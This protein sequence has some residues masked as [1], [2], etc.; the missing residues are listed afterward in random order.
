MN[1]T[2]VMLDQSDKTLHRPGNMYLKTA[3]GVHLDTVTIGPQALIA[4][5]AERRCPDCFPEGS[6]P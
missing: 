1:A 6:G 2:V 4:E 5:R 3:C